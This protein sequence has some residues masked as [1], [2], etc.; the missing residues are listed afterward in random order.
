MIENE[1]VFEAVRRGYN[2]LQMATPDE[3]MD[4]FSNIDTES[5]SGHISNIKGIL[6]EQEIVQALNEQSMDAF[7]FDA[8]NHPASDIFIVDDG[9]ILGELQLK[10]TDSIA[11]IND[12]IALNPDIPI[13]TTSEVAD[14]FDDID[15]VIDSGIDNAALH[16]AVSSTLF[17]D[18]ATDVGM[19]I[20]ADV[21]SD[22]ASEGLAEVIGES[23]LPIPISPLGLLLSLFG[24]PALF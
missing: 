21:L 16:E 8:T 18:T 5:I 10:A 24:I 20:G 13:I 4:Y 15:M 22:T 11:Y 19:D 23:I 3:I 9:E 6:F 14:S 1:D 7:L 2:D 12:T 17:E